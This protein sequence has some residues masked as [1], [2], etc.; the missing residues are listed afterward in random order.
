VV[1]VT[2]GLYENNLMAWSAESKPVKVL[3]ELPTWHCPSFLSHEEMCCMVAAIIV[4]CSVLGSTGKKETT[5]SE[6]RQEGW[7]LQDK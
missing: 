3:A 4:E 2:D 7:T 6:T 1:E 5:V